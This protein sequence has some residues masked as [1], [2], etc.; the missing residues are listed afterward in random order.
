MGVTVMGVACRW[1]LDL[2]A[3][4]MKVRQRVTMYGDPRSRNLW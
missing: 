1:R 3:E 2:F 4:W